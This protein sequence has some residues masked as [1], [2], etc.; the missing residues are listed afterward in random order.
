MKANRRCL[1]RLC[2]LFA[3]CMLALG[4]GG[5]APPH[6]TEKPLND[7][8]AGVVEDAGPPDAPLGSGGTGG[9]ISTGASATDSGGSL[10]TTGA[11]GAIGGATSTDASGSG[12]FILAGSTPPVG[13]TTAT[14]GTPGRGGFAGTGGT[15]TTT[16]TGSG[17][18]TFVAGGTPPAVDQ[19]AGLKFSTATTI[20]SNP[21][22][23]VQVTVSDTAKAQDAYQKT[24]ALPV[25]RPGIRS[26]GM[27]SGITYRLTFL[28]AN[29]LSL[30][31]TEDPDGCGYVDIPGTCVRQGYPLGYWSQLAQDLGI[32]VCKIYPN[33][34]PSV[35]QPDGGMSCTCAKDADCP[36]GLN[37]G[38]AVADGCAAQGVCV[39]NN[40]QPG[41]CLS[42][43]G[44][45]GCDGQ[46][47]LPVMGQNSANSS[48]ILYTSAPSSGKIGPCVGIPDAAASDATVTPTGS[49]SVAR[50]NHTAPLLGSGQ[51][52]VTG[53][54]SH[55]KAL[56]S[57]ELYDPAVGTF[58]T[59]GNMIVARQ[60]HTATLL[61]DGKVLVAGGGAPVGQTFAS[62]ELYDPASGTFAATGSMTVARYEHTATLLPNGK[63]LIA[64]GS[65]SLAL[66]SAELY[67]PGTGTF[68]ATGSMTV[69]RESHTATLLADGTVL[70]AGGV[71]D[72]VYADALASAERYDPSSGAFAAT[73]S[74]TAGR[75]KHT[76]TLLSNGKTLMV[77]GAGGGSAALASAETFDPSAGTFAVA[78]RPNAART[79]HI[80]TLLSNGTVL[81]AGGDYE[82]GALASAEVYDPDTG[83]FTVTRS[84]TVARMLSTATRLPSGA[85]L[86]AGGDD[87]S[88]GA[89]ASA[90][91]FLSAM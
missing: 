45:C 78:Q 21:P 72:G 34:M 5:S 6:R 19:I 89:I 3:L 54:Y 36:A 16:D 51:V 80:A 63:V 88:V 53:G 38:Y 17:N 33:S 55:G 74:M 65:S 11:G 9:A 41:A 14:G 79:D 44:M 70:I 25:V 73:G 46:N 12:G 10:T 37:C 31:V 50:E 90:E 26:C 75:V 30:T 2:S 15:G 86:I 61:L 13:G 4:C 20:P 27:D 58:A 64:G 32:P 40:C 39:E 77:G 66:A 67:D 57:A 87:G 42:P 56:A 69:A 47:I 35:S 24:L 8:A 18:C 81:I 22:P 7:A 68:T 59:T 83:T 91:L 52:L 85:V 29:G 43:A 71:S 1:N 62:A 28:F 76:A 60:R 82:F 49:M 84:L 48:T 23:S